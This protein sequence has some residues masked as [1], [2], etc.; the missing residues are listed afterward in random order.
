MLELAVDTLGRGRELAR[1]QREGLLGLE[2]VDDDRRGAAMAAQAR[3]V[4]RHVAGLRDALLHRGLPGMCSNG[5]RDMRRLGAMLVAHRR[6]IADQPHVLGLV[7]LRL[8]LVGA[9]ALL[10]TQPD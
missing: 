4:V 8:L 3:L 5:R 1:W 9:V 7:A 6:R 10:L 2:H